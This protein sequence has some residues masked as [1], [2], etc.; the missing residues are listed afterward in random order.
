MH[1]DFW[2]ERW[3]KGQIGFHEPKP[4]RFLTA[5]FERLGLARGSTVFV[6]LCGKSLDMLWLAEQGQRVVGVELSPLACEAFFAE[7]NLAAA[8]PQAEGRFRVHR[9]RQLPITLY[10]GDFFELSAAHLGAVDAWYDR[11][12]LIALPGELRRRYVQ[13]LKTALL[14][15][16]TRGLL[17]TVEYD[18]STFPGPPH[19]VPPAEVHALWQERFHIELAGQGDSNNPIPLL[20]KAWL[21][22]PL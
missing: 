16:H 2:H 13:H 5:H 6:P 19:C 17:I 14:A 7:N 15:P 20:E 9:A 18:P 10:E 12:S 8:T 22:T 11:A 4:G 21:L 3:R 1:E